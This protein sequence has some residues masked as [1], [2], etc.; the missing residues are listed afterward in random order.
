MRPAPSGCSCRRPTSACLPSTRATASSAR[1]FGNHG[2][3]D[4]EPLLAA[5]QPAEGTQGTQ[6]VTPAAVVRDTVVVSTIS[7]K[8]RSASFRE[9]RHPRL[10]RAHRGASWTW[11][12]LV[13]D[14]AG[15]HRAHAGQRGRRQQLDAHVGRQRA[16]PGLHADRQPG[17]ELLGR[18][19][20]GRQQ[21]GQLHRRAARLD[22]R[23]GVGLPDPAPRRLGPRRRLAADRGGHA[24]G[25]RRRS[26]RCSSW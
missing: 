22:R 13:R 10:R 3:V 6:L 23:S 11:D 16:R 19:S 15:R 4:F 2:V 9:W 17:A 25:R 18:P 14:G 20:A 8:F 26:R 5:L 24:P 7:N 12:P 21:V 1:D